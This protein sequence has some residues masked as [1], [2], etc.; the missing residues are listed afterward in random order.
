MKEENYSIRLSEKMKNFIIEQAKM[1]GMLPS[2][3][4]RFLLQR[5]MEKTRWES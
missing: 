3:Y 5:E 2:E 4:L 1:R